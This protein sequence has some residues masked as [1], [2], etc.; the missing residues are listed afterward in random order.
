MPYLYVNTL[1]TD[2]CRIV[3]SVEV[4]SAQVCLSSAQ[5]VH[6]KCI[7]VPGKCTASVQ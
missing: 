5:Q 1:G 2:F 7:T 4:L 3:V 6:N